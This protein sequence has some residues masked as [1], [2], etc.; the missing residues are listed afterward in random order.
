MRVLLVKMSSMGD[1]I[2]NLPVVDDIRRWHPDAQ[3]DWVVE[4]P[5]AGLVSLHPGVARVIPMA[6]RRWRKRLWDGE[7]RREMRAFVSGMRAT[8]YDLIVDTQAL[9]K[10]ALV[11][12]LAHG[13]RVGYAAGACREGAAA[14]F[15]DRRMAYAPVKSVHAVARYRALAAWALGQ[16]V[17]GDP[18][19]GIALH[20]VAP[21]WLA[22]D[23]RTAVLLPATARA[24]KQWPRERWVDL[25]RALAA[26]GLTCLV[27]WGSVSERFE[28]TRLAEQMGGGAQAMP[29]AFDLVRWAHLLK[30]ARVCIGVDT[31]L[32]YL[33]AAVGTPTV[34][35]YCDSAP[36][37]AGITVDTPHLNLGDI[38][39]APTSAQVIAAARTLLA[40]ST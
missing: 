23:I 19:Y 13:V 32:T 26:D 16:V 25:G 24:A 9:V 1:V 37:Q 11:A 20:P 3:I 31:G 30:S 17:T 15:Y 18:H 36:A 8:S 21:A 5:Y 27:G 28:A 35:V 34:G 12:R 14:W 2:H 6:W 40:A 29:D 10:S 33:A 4:A 7:V 38:G 39:Q 22:A